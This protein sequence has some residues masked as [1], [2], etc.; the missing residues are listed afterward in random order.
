MFF[1]LAR[2]GKTAIKQLKDVVLDFYTA[3][4][5]CRAKD[6]NYITCC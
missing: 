1:L 3:E 6:I 4:D 5:I 2:Y